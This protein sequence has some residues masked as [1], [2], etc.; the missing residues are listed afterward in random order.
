MFRQR[1]VNSSPEKYK[2]ETQ[3]KARA[4]AASSTYR[5]EDSQNL[6]W[7]VQKNDTRSGDPMVNCMAPL[8]C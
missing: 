5:V 8:T 1:L 6:A 4:E 2:T 3:S 7:I